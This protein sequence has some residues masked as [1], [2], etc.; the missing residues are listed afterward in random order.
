MAIFW[1]PPP[2][3]YIVTVTS[4]VNTYQTPSPLIFVDVIY[5]CPQ[6]GKQSKVSFGS[7]FSKQIELPNSQMFLY[8]LGSL[9]DFNLFGTLFRPCLS[10]STSVCMKS[11]RKSKTL[12]LGIAINLL[13]FSYSHAS[14]DKQKSEVKWSSPLGQ[15]GISLIFCVK[16]YF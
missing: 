11:N 14:L 2:F 7:L 12:Q 4:S 13:T 8:W 6:S 3:V 15:V 9:S 10:L 1:P 16:Q 5:G